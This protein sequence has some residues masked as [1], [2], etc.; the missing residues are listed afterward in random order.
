MSLFFLIKGKRYVI[1]NGLTVVVCSMIIFACAY[2]FY[3]RWLV[4]TW[5]IDPDAKT[6]AYRFE[7]GKDFAPAS[8]FTV[9]AHQFSSITGAGPV[10]GPIIA[11]MFRLGSGSAVDSYRWRFLRSCA[12]FYRSLCFR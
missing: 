9:F 1:M 12:R 2:V 6:P 5:G 11:A 8:K 4:K 3:G 10:T 7:N